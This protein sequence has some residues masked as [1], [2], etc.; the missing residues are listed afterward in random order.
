MNVTVLV[1]IHIH[2]GQVSH[3]SLSRLFTFT[4][5]AALGACTL[6]DFVIGTVR[7]GKTRA[8]ATEWSVE[9]VNTCSCAQSNIVLSCPG[10]QTYDPLNPS[11]FH[12]DGDLCS[13]IQGR[14]LA[15][16]ASVKFTYAWDPPFVLKPF[17]ARSLC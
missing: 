1:R 9:I 12:R 17:S 6:N 8:G 5:R 2:S 13:V 16:K 14:P 11:V 7:N 10:F 3:E 15:S 4:L